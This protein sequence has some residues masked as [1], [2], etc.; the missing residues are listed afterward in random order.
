MGKSTGSSCGNGCT[1]G[2]AETRREDMLSDAVG[3]LK[4]EDGGTPL[5]NMLLACGLTFAVVRTVPL[6]LVALEAVVSSDAFDNA[7]GF[8]P[9]EK[10]RE[11]A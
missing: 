2:G 6:P 9:D 11:R 7:R 4:D 3:R 8:V 1:C 5:D 10:E